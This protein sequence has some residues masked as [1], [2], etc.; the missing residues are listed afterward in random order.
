[1]RTAKEIKKALRAQ[2]D[3]TFCFA[4]GVLLIALSLQILR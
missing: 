4:L 2:V 1:M 3:L